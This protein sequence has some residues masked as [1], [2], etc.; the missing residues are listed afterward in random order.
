MEEFIREAYENDYTHVV[1]KVSLEGD[2]NARFFYNEFEA[3]NYYFDLNE[4]DYPSHMLIETK[5][6]YHRDVIYVSDSE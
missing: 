6:Y 5:K 2:T 1:I 3:E 4:Q